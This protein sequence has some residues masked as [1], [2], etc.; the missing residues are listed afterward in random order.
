MPERNHHGSRKWKRKYKGTIYTEL[1]NGINVKGKM[2]RKLKRNYKLN[3]E[4]KTIVKE[5]VKQRM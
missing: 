3:K 1:E 2:C 5:R 4:N